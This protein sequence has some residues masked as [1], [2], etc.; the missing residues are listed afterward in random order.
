VGLP[1]PVVLVCSFD[2]FVGVAKASADTLFSQDAV[3][4]SQDVSL[5][6]PDEW[7]VLISDSISSLSTQEATPFPCSSSTKMTPNTPP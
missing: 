4:V 1:L 5:P 7:I 3:V 2:A 6:V